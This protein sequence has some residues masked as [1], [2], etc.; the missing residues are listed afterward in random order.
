[1]NSPC[2]HWVIDPS[3]PVY[4]LADDLDDL[5]ALDQPRLPQSKEDLAPGDVDNWHFELIDASHQRRHKT[6]MDKVL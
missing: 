6:A 5:F 1:M 3:P 4:L 2:T